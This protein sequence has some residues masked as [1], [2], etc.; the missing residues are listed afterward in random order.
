[1][2]ISRSFTN[3]NAFA[4]KVE[5]M[6]AAANL[7]PPFVRNGSS[8]VSE[9]C[10]PKIDVWDDAGGINISAFLPGIQI[11]D[12]RVEIQDGELSITAKTN[13]VENRQPIKNQV[14]DRQ[15]SLDYFA[16]II[17]GLHQLGKSYKL[18][19]VI[20][21]P[22]D[23]DTSNIS[24]NFSNDMLDLYIPRLSMDNSLYE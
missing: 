15:H 12:V 2:P 1:M 6:N 7:L 14:Y 11:E 23:V 9:Q 5:L 4:K 13:D 10:T 8:K 3:S 18:S 22:V 21:I 16:G 19:R 17:A 24:M 20:A